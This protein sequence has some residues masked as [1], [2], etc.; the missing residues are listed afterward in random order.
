M[1]LGLLTMTNVA[2]AQLIEGGISFYGTSTTNITDTEITAIDFDDYWFGKINY[3]INVTATYGDLDIG[4]WYDD[5]EF[6]DLYSTDLEAD[7]TVDDF[8]T[9][10][11]FSFDLLAI[12]QNF[13]V[14]S[15]GVTTATLIGTG[16]LSFVDFLGN[17][18]GF[19][20][21]AY[22]WAYTTQLSGNTVESSFSASSAAVPAP[23]GVA[24]L[25]MALL[26]FGAIRRSKKG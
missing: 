8:W 1:A 17:T 2:N 25:G 4:R 7:G 3:D 18:H 23:A 10:K 14:D 6:K 19:E 20:E 21:T 22:N 16:M 11:G 15:D 12:E 9:F 24:L 26:G 13:L 5:A